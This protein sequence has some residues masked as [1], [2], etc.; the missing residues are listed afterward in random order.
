MKK[1][2]R[3]KLRLR[4]FQEMGFH[5]DFDVNLASNIETENAFFNKLLDFVDGQE[6][7]I[8]GS[9]NSFY[10]TRTKRDSATDVDRNVVEAWLQQQPEVSSVKVWPLDNSWHGPFKWL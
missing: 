6:L 2:L 3:K 10:V 5:V 7:S 4:E 1:R 8:G 9:M